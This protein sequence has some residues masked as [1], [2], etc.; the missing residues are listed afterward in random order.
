MLYLGLA[1]CSSAV[2][3]IVLKI[4]QE[5]KG[6]RYGIIMGNYLVCILIAFFSLPDRSIVLKGSGTALVCGLIGGAFYVAGLVTMQTNTRLNGATLTA[7]FSKMGIVISLGVSIL[8]FGERPGILQILGVLLCLIALVL[9]T[10]GGESGEKE[11]DPEQRLAADS[12]K[13]DGSQNAISR[14]GDPSPSSESSRPHA[15]ALLAAMF[16]GGGSS[17]MPKVFEQV[18]N[19]AED[20]L[21]FLYLF[22][23][24]AVLTVLLVLLEKKKSG[25][26]LRLPELAAGIAVGVPN[27]FASYLL[28][29]ALVVLPAFLVYPLNSTGA[30]LLVMAVDALFFHQKHTRR[31]MVGILLVLAAMVLLNL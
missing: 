23:A 29:P 24:A 5:P 13:S 8:I 15:G 22:A 17:S 26:S 16:A 20:E 10:G 19:R 1:T 11:M 25:R 9:I 18:G 7:V 31:Q 2:M 30:I 14:K 28:L 4:F 21:F 3:A 6:N 12:A 27:Y